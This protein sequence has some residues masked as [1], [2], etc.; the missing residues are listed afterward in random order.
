MQ[1]RLNTDHHLK[2]S[3]QLAARIEA[4]LVAALDRFGGRITRVEVHLNDENS[5]KAGAADKRCMI[6]A[7]L[8]GHRPVAVSARGDDYDLAV[9]AAADKLARALDSSLGRLDDRRPAADPPS[10]EWK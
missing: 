5:G 9:R 4:D 3:D 1:V 6:E 8:P 7:R 2:A 10:R